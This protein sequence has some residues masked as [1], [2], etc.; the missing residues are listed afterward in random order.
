MRN[1][2]AQPAPKQRTETAMNKLFIC[3]GLLLAIHSPASFAC[4]HCV[5][6][7]IAAVYDHAVVTQALKMKHQVLFFAVDGPLPN[8]EAELQTLQR[9]VASVYGVD[10]NSTRI[11]TAAASLSVAIDP[12]HITIPM[13]ERSLKMKLA[14]RKL[15]LQLL[16]IMDKAAELKTV[17]QP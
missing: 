9:A 14:Q 10:T 6:D 8:T 5:E 7:K 13:I 12:R 17:S 11:S 2:Q 16:R 4:G 3:A 15:S 1:P